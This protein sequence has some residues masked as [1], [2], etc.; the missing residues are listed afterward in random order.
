MLVY[1]RTFQ[2]TLPACGGNSNRILGHDNV[3]QVMYMIAGNGLT[4][5]GVFLLGLSLWPVRKLARQFSGGRV[6]RWWD[7]QSLLILFF[8]AGYLGYL[9]SF[10]RIHT[11]MLLLIVP[12]IFFMGAIYVVLVSFLSL[13]TAVSIKRV[14]LLEKEN[15]TDHLTGIFNRR[16][17]EQRISEEVTRALRYDNDL[18]LMFIDVDHF[19]QVND[20]HGHPVGDT[21]LRNLA[22]LIASGLRESDMAARYGGEEI[23]VLVPH[24]S[25]SNAASLAERLRS[26]VEETPMAATESGDLHITVSIGVATLDAET[27][28]TRTFLQHADKALYMAKQKGRNQIVV[29][30]LSRPMISTPFS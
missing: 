2:Y 5:A 25:L 9:F 30:E 18:S 13:E 20:R 10:W 8:I 24:T 15:I 29:K 17:L 12:S 21:V 4:L 16:Y 19:K 6:R 1:K 14:S 27:V 26:A 23:C 3:M 22:A 28:D 7:V 11:G